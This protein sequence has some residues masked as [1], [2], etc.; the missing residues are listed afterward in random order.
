MASG[1]RTLTQFAASLVNR[2]V[3]G[4]DGIT[5]GGRRNM[6]EVLGYKRQILV[7]DYRGRYRRNEV[8]NRIVKALPKATWRGGAEIAEDKETEQDTEFEK[9]FRD[10]DNRLKVWDVFRRA[11]ILSGIGRYAIILITAPGAMDTPLEHCTL[12]DIALLT[13]YAEGDATIQLYNTDEHSPRYG[14]PE[15]YMLKRGVNPDGSTALNNIA[16]IGKRVHWTRCIHIADGLLDDSIFGEPRLQCVWNRLDDLE[17][18]AGG[19]AEAF[20]KRADQGKQFDLD[21]TMDLTP[22][23][24]VEMQ[25][26]IDAFNHE[27]KRTMRTRGMKINEFGS[28]VADFKSPVES[29]ISL[30]SAGTGIPQR[31]LMGSEQGKLAAKQDKASWDNQVIDRQ[32]DYAGPMIVRPFVDRLVLLGALTEPAKGYTVTWSTIQTMDDEQRAEIGKN[33]VAS[34]SVTR[35]ELRT[36]V[37]GLPALKDGDPRGDEILGGT[38][39]AQPGGAGGFAGAKGAGSEVSW[40]GVQRSA[41]R[42]RGRTQKESTESIR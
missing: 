39:P 21:P 37:L 30:I 18:V 13:P 28:D 41:D 16:G 19:G 34:Q 22:E 1:F 3:F 2:G 15:F 10:L 31:V 36:R 23:Q 7:P 8:A 40:R 17:K 26:E 5:F 33:W 29:I 38:P 32:K 35:N 6:Y 25:N 27:G 9:D 14:L 42:F 20:W 12:D 24:I 4:R 11:D